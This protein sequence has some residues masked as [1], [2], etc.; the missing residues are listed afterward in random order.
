VSETWRDQLVPAIDRVWNDEVAGLARDL[1]AWL[2]G[3][4]TDGA[5]WT[6]TYFEYAFG[7]PID[8]DRDPRSVTDPVRIDERFLLRGSVDLIEAHRTSGALRVTD[9]KTGR[10]RSSPGMVIGGGTVLQPVLYSMAV[11]QITGRPVHESRLSYCT[12]AG[13]FTVFP[14]AVDADNR[15]L[16]VEA[17]EIIDR[18]IELGFLAAAPAEGACAWCDFRPVCGPNEEQ[19]TGRKPTERLRDLFELRIRR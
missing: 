2:R 5:E 9:H 11:E 10:N 14:I 18:A 16:G 4:V 8:D 3:I 12:S 7:L 1:R 6:P 15:R 13:G 17:L 19:R